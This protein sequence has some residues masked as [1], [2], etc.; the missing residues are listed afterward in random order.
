MDFSQ[1]F[2]TII[3]PVILAATGGFMLFTGIHNRNKAEHATGWFPAS[4][5]VTAVSL[6]HHY[7]KG[8][9]DYEPRVEYTYTI[10][11]SLYAGKTFCFGTLR[12]TQAKAQAK[13][14]AY[15]LH[16]RIVVYYNPDK[17]TESVLEREAPGAVGM[18]IGGG[19]IILTGAVLL[20]LP[21]L[22]TNLNW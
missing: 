13:L 15:P 12:T 9:V 11:G 5:E 17:P 2:A 16:G 21:Y 8:G 6:K 20:I 7:R 18:M 10:M 19:F 3:I 1:L 22:V 4:G 14:A